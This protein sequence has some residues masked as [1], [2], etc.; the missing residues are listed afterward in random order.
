MFSTLDLSF[1]SEKTI[2]QRVV[3]HITSSSNCTILYIAVDFFFF[4][5]IFFLCSIFCLKFYYP[6]MG[7]LKVFI[8]LFISGSQFKVNTDEVFA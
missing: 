8:Q 2:L 5:H 6:N 1:S 3:V 7:V 4:L